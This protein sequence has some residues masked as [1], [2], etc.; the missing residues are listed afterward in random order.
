MHACAHTYIYI[1][2]NFLAAIPHSI[3]RLR[4]PRGH[5]LPCGT[6]RLQTHIRPPVVTTHYVGTGYH[7]KA[8]WPAGNRS[9]YHVQV[10]GRVGVEE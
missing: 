6:S 5:M 3:S 2:V 9:H 1:Y 4:T 7:P 8:T 10:R